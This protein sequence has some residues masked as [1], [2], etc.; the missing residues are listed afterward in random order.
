ME[1]LTCKYIINGTGAAP[2]KIEGGANED[3]GYQT[4]P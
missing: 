3:F 4:S 1:V 2:G